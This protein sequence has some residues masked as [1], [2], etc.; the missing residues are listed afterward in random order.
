ML[1]LRSPKMHVTGFDRPNLTYACR[2]IDYEFEKDE[3]LAH[4]LSKQQGSGIVYCATRKKV[5]HL[6]SV[7]A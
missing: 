5:E 1:Q 3:A 6:T 2:R 4:G 7:P